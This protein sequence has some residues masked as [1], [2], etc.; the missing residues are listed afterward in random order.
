ME[1]ANFPA[2]AFHLRKFRLKDSSF[3]SLLDDPVGYKVGIIESLLQTFPR[4][5]FILVGDSGEKDPEV[6]GILARR[7]PS[8]VKRILIRNITDESNTGGR[9]Q[10]AFRELPPTLWTCF[11]D[12]SDL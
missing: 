6:Y 5:T 4:R 7:F 11:E 8:Q 3:L 10:D 1:D 9:F 2:G 12:P